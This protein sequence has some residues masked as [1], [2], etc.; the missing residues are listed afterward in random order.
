MHPVSNV[1]DPVNPS[2]KSQQ[3]PWLYKRVGRYQVQ[4]LLGEGSHGRVFRAEDLQLGRQVALKV[5][6]LSTDKQPA[7]IIDRAVTEA[8]LAAG[9]EHP[10]IV[11]VYEVSE[12]ADVCYIAMEM[13][14]GGNLKDLVQGNG[15]MDYRRACQIIAE[16]AEALAYAHQRGVI[17][18]DIKP[19]NL[20]LSGNGRCKLADF[21]LAILNTRNADGKQS[22]V[23]GT[24][25]FIAPELINAEPAT[26]RSDIFSLGATLWYLLTASAPFAADTVAETLDKQLHDP[27]P[28]LTRLQPDVPLTLSRAICKAM[29]K[30]PADR[31]ENAEQF[32]SV[33]RVHTIPVGATGSSLADLGLFAPP[34]PVPVRKVVLWGGLAAIIGVAAAGAFVYWLAGGW[35]PPPVRPPG[36]VV[37]VHD[38]PAHP[39]AAA[40][41]IPVP[42]SQPAATNPS[43]LVFRATDS[44]ALAHLAKTDDTTN[45]TLVTVEGI[46]ASNQVSR[47]AKYFR[48][49][50]SNSDNPDDFVC[51]YKPDLLPNLQDKF[52]SVD[53]LGLPGK[54]IRVSGHVE[55]YKDRPT[56]KIESADQIDVVK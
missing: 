49:S 10:H 32:A 5:F 42:P 56:I 41:R 11:H 47:H 54:R 2:V 6:S 25:Q 50:F 40:L 4:A 37:V 51:V 22:N 7:D 20:M 34:D 13:A 44:A 24:P 55:L 46:V 53:G 29:E 3:P 28:D 36:D 48:I 16:I 1:R 12:T 33:L 18:R 19:A 21:G 52:G 35:A 30:S 8:K 43:G 23:A 45:P 15:P 17:H 26:P 38:T 39:V 27:L 31:Y 9:L 14:E